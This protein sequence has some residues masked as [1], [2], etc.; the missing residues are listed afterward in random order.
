[1][2]LVV[3]LK[4]LP[5][6][7]AILLG[8]CA[9]WLR[10]FPKPV[11]AVDTLNRYALYFGFPL[12]IFEGFCR[13]ALKLSSNVGFYA[14]HA[15][16]AALLILVIV[17]MGGLFSSLRQVRGNLVL[18]TLFGNVAYLGIPMCSLLLGKSYLGLISLSVALQVFFAM[19]LGPLCL[20]LWGEE[21]QE[22]T[23]RT[24]L[25][26]LFKQ[27]LLWAPILG[28]TARLLP[29]AWLYSMA[30]PLSFFAASAAPVALFLLG[31]HIWIHQRTLRK[32][33]PS[34]GALLFCK[35]LLV[36]V[37]IF[38]IGGGFVSMGWM[39]LREWQVVQLLSTMPTAITT[40]SIARDMRQN[41]GLMAQAILLS[42]LVA[43]LLLPLMAPWWMQW[44]GVA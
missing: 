4:I 6:L 33:E 44:T 34:V 29:E 19:L 10:V 43:L 12:L 30:K 16:I 1:M 11:D 38:T 17:I 24:L 42:T 5:L 15:L 13:P 36:P 39:D 23:W 40:F 7:L 41:E 22:E 14:F 31:L 21:G 18:G 37:V 25:L 8:Y 2:F 27:P 3:F 28:F 20:L 35:L 32:I 9:G 26:K